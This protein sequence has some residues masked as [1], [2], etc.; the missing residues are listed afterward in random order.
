MSNG[1]HSD[2][3]SY[4]K[5]KRV[6]R[7]ASDELIEGGIAVVVEDENEFRERFCKEGVIRLH[8]R[9]L[10]RIVKEAPSAF[11]SKVKKTQRNEDNSFSMLRYLHFIVLFAL[12]CQLIFFYTWPVL[13]DRTLMPLPSSTI[14]KDTSL[15]TS[16]SPSPTPT[17]NPTTTTTTTTT[18]Q[19]SSTT[20][21]ETTETTTPTPSPTTPFQPL[22]MSQQ[23]Q[24]AVTALTPPNKIPIMISMV[25]YART[26]WGTFSISLVQETLRSNT[27]YP[28]IKPE[29]CTYIL[30]RNQVPSDVIELHEAQ[31]AIQNIVCGPGWENRYL[32]VPYAV[33]H[34]VNGG[35]EGKEDETDTSPFVWGHRNVAVVFM[36]KAELNEAQAKRASYYD[37]VIAGSSWNAR[38]VARSL[39]DHGISIGPG[40]VG[41]HAVLQG[42][43]LDVFASG[44]NKNENMPARLE[45]ILKDPNNFVVFAGGAFSF[46]KGHDL[47]IDA[48][49][50]LVKMELPK[51]IVLVTAWVNLL[52]QTRPNLRDQMRSVFPGL[53]STRKFTQLLL[54]FFIH[55]QHL[56]HT[57][58]NDMSEWLVK[59]KGIPKENHFTLGL[60]SHFEIASV[61]Q[62]ADAALFTNRAEGGTNLPAM[63]AMASG[64]AVI[65][66]ANTGHMDL[67]RLRDDDDDVDRLSGGKPDHV[68]KWWK[69]N[70]QNK[71]LS[72][73]N[74]CVAL[75]KQKQV[76]V[77]HH[78]Q[79]SSNDNHGWGES[80][81]EEI[82]NAIRNLMENPRRAKEMGINAARKMRRFTWTRTALRIHRILA[83]ELGL[84]DLDLKVKTNEK[85]RLNKK[86]SGDGWGRR[87][88]Q[89]SKDEIVDNNLDLKRVVDR[90][91]ELLNRRDLKSSEIWFEKATEMLNLSKLLKGHGSKL[92]LD[93]AVVILHTIAQHIYEAQNRLSEAEQ[94]Y[95]TIIKLRNQD[96]KALNGLGRVLGPQ[97]LISESRDTLQQALS[98]DPNFADAHFH[99]TNVLLMEQEWA[100]AL[101]HARQGLELCINT[102]DPRLPSF[103]VLL[104]RAEQSYELYGGE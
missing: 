1:D 42:V 36:E 80:D 101:K 94:T 27:F 15:S 75:Q 9:Y 35:F 72:R 26:G 59:T 17:P 91:V 47:I 46:R 39:K 63:E 51:R 76:D 52:A 71:D 19:P 98:L 6:L 104:S 100:L 44:R 20:T 31:K 97:G 50:K 49:S 82:V 77:V 37:A 48:I 102:D 43:H 57:G 21:C 66:S 92:E 60:S 93:N 33:V 30:N 78:W 10:R 4:L 41:V 84:K 45:K 3:V 89:V 64:L 73:Q 34:A 40:N 23:L 2:W 81:V 99:L 95:R 86:S 32:Q 90:A 8:A 18:S 12:A 61:L 68:E 24:D 69:H 11:H 53:K 103:Q 70:K 83:K 38:G 88:H 58:P 67:I 65:L 29:G 87:R 28:I 56:T 62:R 16:S 85:S 54:H 96:I 7:Y 13:P 5:S 79:V 14:Q 22:Q 74:H 55:S 25:P